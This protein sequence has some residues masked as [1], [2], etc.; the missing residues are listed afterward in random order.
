MLSNHDSPVCKSQRRY[1]PSYLIWQIA[2]IPEW[3]QL[4]I[5]VVSEI[6]QTPFYVNVGCALDTLA[7]FQSR[8]RIIHIEWIIDE[9]TDHSPHTHSSQSLNL[10]ALYF[11]AACVPLR[12]SYFG[13]A[14]G[15]PGCQRTH[16]DTR[17]SFEVP[18][19]VNSDRNAQGLID[20][21]CFPGV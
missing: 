14:R 5:S 17:L 4:Y 2:F 13:V 12:I 16:R 3:R 19:A 20:R 8:C 1:T 18:S 15:P 6:S 7:H 11:S 10:E 9:A 21:Q